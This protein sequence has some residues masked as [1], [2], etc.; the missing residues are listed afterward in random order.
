MFDVIVLIRNLVL[1]AVLAWLGLEFAP[2]NREA[3][4]T[5]P[6]SSVVASI[7]G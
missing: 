1:A 3:P 6:Q 4:E 5:A 7:F 2:D